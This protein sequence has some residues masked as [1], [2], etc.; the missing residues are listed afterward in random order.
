MS[1]KKNARKRNKIT[2]PLAVIGGLTPA[3][4]G[5]WNRRNSGTEIA[6]YL[7]KGF[8]GVDPAT[9]TLNFANFRMGLLPVMFGV[10]A[11]KVASM[12]GLN[13]AIA[14]TGLPWIRI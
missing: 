8:T 9:G 7:Q 13:R 4:V 5:V 12:A 14:R 11:H 10:V 3:I 2:L 1:K 6:S